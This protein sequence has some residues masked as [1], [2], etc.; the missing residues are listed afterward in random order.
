MVKY[1]IVSVV[2]EQYRK[3]AY[4][5]V[6]SALDNLDLDNIHEIC[7]LNTGMSEDDVSKL[8]SLHAK[9]KIIKAD[10]IISSGKGWDS[11]W[12]E[13]VDL[14]TKFV[15]DY[16]SSNAIPTCMVDID[17][18]FTNDITDVMSVDKDIVVCDRSEHLSNSPYIASFVGFL[19][20]SKSKEFLS[21]WIDCMTSITGF[22][23][24]E[25]PALCKIA[26]NSSYNIGTCSY[27]I[28]GLYYDNLY[29][30]DTRIIH[31]KSDGSSLNL[32]MEEGVKVRLEKF[33]QFSDIIQ[34]YLQDV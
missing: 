23:T 18:M 11:G 5:F 34:G 28:I 7:L 25:T 13:N 1:S 29:T 16:I 33:K 31:F 14:K 21:E 4:V 6:K 17:C 10:Q 27:K 19:N 8:E 2:N 12:K 26:T 15:K 32:P 9:V 24:K 20:I 22:Q 3:F 30:T